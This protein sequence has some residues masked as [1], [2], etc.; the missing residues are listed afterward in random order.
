MD[1]R[2]VLFDPTLM[3]RICADAGK[4]LQTPVEQLPLFGSEPL[5]VQA[6]PKAAVLALKAL[7]S[8]EQTPLWELQWCT[9]VLLY[10]SETLERGFEE[11][12]PPAVFN[13]WFRGGSSVRSAML[14][15]RERFELNLGGM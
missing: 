15:F 1:L 11:G 6:C 2:L 3:R 8:D 7:S 10:M 4:D 5:D 13:H 9:L 14:P 12:T